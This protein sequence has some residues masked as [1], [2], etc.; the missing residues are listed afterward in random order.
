MLS[1]RNKIGI[2][3]LITL[4]TSAAMWV[5]GGTDSS[6]ITVQGSLLKVGLVM[7][8]VWLAYPQLAMLPIWLATIGVG[9]VLAVLLFKKAAIFVIPLLIIIWLLRPRPPKPKKKPK[10]KPWFSRGSST[11]DR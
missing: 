2:V 1:F 8:A 11:S 7:G 3:S 5:F 10:E 6:F 9:S 4:V